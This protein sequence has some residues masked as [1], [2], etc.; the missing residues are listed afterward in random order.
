MLVEMFL[1]H[2]QLEVGKQLSWAPLSP[3]GSLWN[4]VLFAFQDRTITLQGQIP[5]VIYDAFVLPYADQAFGARLG[6]CFWL[7]AV[8]GSGLFLAQGCFWLR[9]VFGSGLFQPCP[10]GWRRSS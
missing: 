7:R 2:D 9:A 6:G 1:Y 4:P 3:L 10:P 8:F 5:W